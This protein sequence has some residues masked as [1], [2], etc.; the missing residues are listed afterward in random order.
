MPVGRAAVALLALVVAGSACGGPSPRAF[1]GEPPAAPLRVAVLPLANYTGDRDAPDRIAPVLYV[2]L[3]RRAGYAITEPGRVE[4]ALTREPWLL[5][6]RIPPDLVD[7]LGEELGVDGLL[8]GSILAH[9]Y[10]DR[11]GERVPEVSLS[12]RILRTPGGDVWWSAHHSR[13]G[14]DGESVFGMGKVESLESLTAAVVADLVRTLPALSADD[15][16]GRA[17]PPVDEE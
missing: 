1:V 7:K 6:D 2:E 8:V 3:A 14:R 11:G 5:T 13:D 15:R 17:A 16:G 12:V 10:A 9:G 4:E